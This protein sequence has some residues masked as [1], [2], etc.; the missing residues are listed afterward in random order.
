MKVHLIPVFFYGL[1]VSNS[2]LAIDPVYEGEKGIRTNV[3]ETNCLGCHSSSIL[4]R[5]KLR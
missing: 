3:F 1:I 5:M 2:A 4:I